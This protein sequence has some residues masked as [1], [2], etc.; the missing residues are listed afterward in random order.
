MP[1]PTKGFEVYVDADFCGNWNRFEA[2]TD[3]GTAKSRA[4][5]IIYYAGCPIIFAS[6][7]ESQVALSTTEAEYIA[8]SMSLRDAIPAMQLVAEVRSKGFPVLCTEP[9]VYCKV[10]EDNSG[11]LELA[12][13]PKFR[14]RTKH[15]CVSLHHFRVQRVHAQGAS[16]DFSHPL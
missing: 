6:R 1:D 14:P 15:L 11:A 10:F 5:W 13:L 2:P 12:R 8:L 3:P 7:L 9:Y 16:E 4:G